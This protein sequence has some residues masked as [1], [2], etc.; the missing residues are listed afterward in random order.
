[1]VLEEEGKRWNNRRQGELFQGLLTYS[2]WLHSLWKNYY[3]SDYSRDSHR[4]IVAGGN[5]LIFGGEK[6]VS[7]IGKTFGIKKNEHPPII[8][9]QYINFL[10]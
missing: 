3:I 9:Y 6:L 10:W 1:M 2:K 5:N 4:F 7:L 8:K